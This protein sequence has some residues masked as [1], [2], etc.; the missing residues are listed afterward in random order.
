MIAATANPTGATPASSWPPV[1]DYL[2]SGVQSNSSN[3]PASAAP[4]KSAPSM[5]SSEASD[6]DYTLVCDEP[7]CVAAAFEEVVSAI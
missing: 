3:S 5:S 4:S 1:I 7:L 2:N 6:P